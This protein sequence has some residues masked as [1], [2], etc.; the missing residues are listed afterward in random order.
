M[1]LFDGLSPS[2]KK[3][4][5]LR[6]QRLRGENPNLDKSEIL[7]EKVTAKGINPAFVIHCIRSEILAY[8]VRINRLG[9]R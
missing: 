4:I 6:P 7:A 5:S 2:N 1:F 3:L 9:Y 8:S